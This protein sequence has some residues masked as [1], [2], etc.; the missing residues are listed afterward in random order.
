MAPAL[1]FL[2]E[3]AGLAEDTVVQHVHFEIPLPAGFEAN[4]CD[5][6]F[7]LGNMSDRF[8]LE[9][10][11]V[12]SWHNSCHCP[13]T[14]HLDQEIPEMGNLQCFEFKQDVSSGA[15]MLVSCGAV[16][17]HFYLPS[18]PGGL[19]NVCS[20]LN[21]E[22]IFDAS[23]VVIQLLEEVDKNYLTLDLNEID[24]LPTTTFDGTRYRLLV[25]HPDFKHFVDPI[26]Q[27][28]KDNQG[29]ELFR[30]CV[31][32]SN[33]ILSFRDDR[34][35]DLFGPMVERIHSQLIFLK[36]NQVVTFRCNG[37]VG[38]YGMGGVK[39]A[40]FGSLPDDFE[41]LHAGTKALY[42]IPQKL[43]LNLRFYMI[44]VRKAR[45]IANPNAPAYM[46]HT[47]VAPAQSLPLMANTPLY[48]A[49]TDSFAQTI[50]AGATSAYAQ[51]SS[52]ISPY[53][54]LAAS[55]NTNILGAG[56]MYNSGAT[57]APVQYIPA[58]QLPYSS[59]TAMPGY[60]MTAPVQ[61][62]PQIQVNLPSAGAPKVQIASGPQSFMTPFTA[63]NT[64]MKSS[65][66]MMP[67]VPTNLPVASPS[68]PVSQQSSAT[69]QRRQVTG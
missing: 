36:R 56:G 40:T 52:T 62:Q 5:V 12:I 4:Q 54:P 15:G 69:S 31:R 30:A 34:R 3:Q 42:S 23:A 61:S 13:V 26:K 18:Q 20:P 33:D 57:A 16:P 17:Y 6:P 37:T 28:I 32:Y 46:T 53:G 7:V 68:Q 50:P 49:S 45:M 60:P 44:P 19:T 64:P 58:P 63:G 2:A 39:P 47:T 29:Q 66:P 65:A 59:P 35:Q 10:I 51:P 55:S 21:P 38:N 11:E 48:S 9:K 24:L 25:E 8:I 27:Y 41:N 1:N 22:V 14:V 67:S 43:S